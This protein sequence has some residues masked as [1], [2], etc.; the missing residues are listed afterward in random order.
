MLFDVI[1]GGSLDS[2]LMS[3]SSSFR[4]ENVQHMTRDNQEISR[5]EQKCAVMTRDNEILETRY[6]LMKGYLR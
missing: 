1:E 4:F 6:D 2:P 3:Y 5:D